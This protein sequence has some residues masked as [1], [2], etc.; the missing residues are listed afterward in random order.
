MVLELIKK[1]KGTIQDTQSI[2]F[3]ANDLINKFLEKQPK[4]YSIKILERLVND[5]NYNFA[6]ETLRS[7][8]KD[9]IMLSA[10]EDG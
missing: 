9:E 8:D 4:C 6:A 7:Q 3:C 5:K 10:Q 1:S 2:K